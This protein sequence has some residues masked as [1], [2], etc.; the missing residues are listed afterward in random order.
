MYLDY[1]KA[2]DNV[3]HVR[4]LKKAG[5]VVHGITG[6]LLKWIESF[7][8][9]RTQQVVVNGVPSSTSEVASGVPQVFGTSFISAFR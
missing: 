9:G 8:S 5:G 7:L 3:P 6:D 4:L 2:F 1:S